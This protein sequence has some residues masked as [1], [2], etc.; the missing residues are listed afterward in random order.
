MAP[1]PQVQSRRGGQFG[2]RPDTRAHAYHFRRQPGPVVQRN[3][4]CSDFRR[5][6]AQQNLNIISLQGLK[7]RNGHFGIHWGHHL[8]RQ[9]HDAHLKPAFPQVF[10][11][12]Q[13]D[14]PAA[15][16]D[17]RTGPLGRVGNPIHVFQGV[18]RQHV[19]LPGAGYGQADWLGPGSQYQLI[20]GQAERFS[21]FEIHAADLLIRPADFCHRMAG[22]DIQAKTG[23]QHGL[24]GYRQQGPIP[25]HPSYVIR[26]AAVGKGNVRP[27]FQDGNPAGRVQPGQ[28]GGKTHSPRDTPNDNHVPSH[29]FLLFDKIVK[30]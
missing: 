19:G 22:T 8:V 1:G 24:G 18:Q 17:G 6:P 9:L 20:I 14:E 16:D 13:P 27:P 25:D 7:Y 10:R 30:Q 11:Q 23:L 26:H 3:L 15:D 12:F 28:P 2:A 29:L 21:G 4:G 5:F